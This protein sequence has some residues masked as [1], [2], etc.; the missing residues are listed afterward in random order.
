MAMIV[1]ES[2]CE[3]Q[4]VCLLIKK[5]NVI[6]STMN[7]SDHPYLI[8]AVFRE[9]EMAADLIVFKI[10]SDKRITTAATACVMFHNK[11]MVQQLIKH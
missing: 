8:F 2:V 9:V 7:H 3:Q 11:D 4:N 10:I 5:S 1:L 6:T